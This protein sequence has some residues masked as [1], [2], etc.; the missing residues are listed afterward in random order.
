MFCEVEG[1][2]E[3]QLGWFTFAKIGML[4][5]QWTYLFSNWVALEIYPYSS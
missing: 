2:N 5:K 1:L 3:E 4:D